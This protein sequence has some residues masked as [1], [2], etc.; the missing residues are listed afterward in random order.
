MQKLA[1]AG[2]LP[3]TMLLLLVDPS[4]ENRLEMLR[5]PAAL[6]PQK[7]RV[8]VMPLPQVRTVTLS[9]A[10]LGPAVPVLTQST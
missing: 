3:E 8:A 5:L 9:A 4:P 1:L 7:R 2:W 10:R 6:Q